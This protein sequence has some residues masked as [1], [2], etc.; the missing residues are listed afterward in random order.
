MFRLRSQVVLVGYN[1]EV[2]AWVADLHESA[3]EKARADQEDAAKNA[4]ADATD[5][6]GAKP[7]QKVTVPNDV[8][9][10]KIAF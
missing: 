2:T 7:D 10:A 8:H 6:G 3:G 4:A 1:D 9:E 5:D